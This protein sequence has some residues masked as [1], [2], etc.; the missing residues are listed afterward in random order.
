M[1]GS[2]MR[3]AISPVGFSAQGAERLSACKT[4]ESF[5]VVYVE[6]APHHRRSRDAGGSLKTQSN[7]LPYS[8]PEKF[9]DK[10]Q[11]R[12]DICKP[13]PSAKTQQQNEFPISC[14]RC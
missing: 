6:E 7:L 11:L 14:G 4:T 5:T 10:E 9:D 8:P 3:I 1:Y 12:N 13:Y 2:D